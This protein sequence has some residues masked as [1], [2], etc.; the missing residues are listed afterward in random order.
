MGL[1]PYFVPIEEEQRKAVLKKHNL[2]SEFLL[3]IGNVK[4]HKNVNGLVESYIMAL[5]QNPDLPALVISGRYRQL[6]TAIPN[7]RTLITN[8]EV[9]SRIIFTGYLPTE[10][11]PAIYSQALMFLF[12]SF[13]E[14]FGLPN[15]EAMACGTPV[16]TSNCS[17]IPEVVENSAI[18]IDPYNKEMIADAILN[19]AANIELQQTYRERGI[20]RAQKFSWNKSAREHVA[21]YNQTI[22]L[23]SRQTGKL[24]PSCSSSTKAKK[25]T[26]CLWINTATGLVVAKSFY[27]I[28]SRTFALEISGTFLFPFLTKDYSQKRSKK[29]NSVIGASLFGSL[30]HLAALIPRFLAI[31]LTPSKVLICSQKSSGR[32]T[33]T[34]YT[35]TEAEPF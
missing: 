12:P 19:L 20:S 11:L 6:I 17:S 14:G 28:F 1:I 21:V 2:P 29:K 24:F 10:D 23:P 31:S 26:S 9:E 13:Y 5:K 25:P 3:F 22:G 30:L 35:V 8:K 27:W 15:L 32:T 16:I 34:L 18:L 4:P 33:S 7:L